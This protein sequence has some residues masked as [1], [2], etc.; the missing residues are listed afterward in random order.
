[1]S[2]LR[3]FSFLSLAFAFGIA[4]CASSSESA[5]PASTPAGSAVADENAVVV[6]DHNRMDNASALV[7]LIEPQGGG[8]RSSL[9]V[10]DP[11]STK[12]FSYKAP[13]PG[14]YR[15]I[16]QGSITSPQFRLSNREIATW[17]MQTN[18]VTVVNK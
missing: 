4:A 16:A 15:L 12:R 7:I 3:R 17:N 11:G 10:V 14:N 6:V 18:R 9:G 8:V 13:A 2:S 5:T 1:M